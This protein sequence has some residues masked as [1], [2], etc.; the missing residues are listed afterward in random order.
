MEYTKETEIM[1][2]L[3][4]MEELLEEGKTS[5]ITS[6]VSI[7]RDE[8]FEYIKDIRMKLPTELQ[9]SVWIV[10]ERNKILAE[11]QGE[12][13]LIIQ[14][15]QETLQKM[16]EQHEIT[17]YAE[18]R[19]QMILENARKDS[20]EIRIGAIE[21]ANETVKGVEQQLKLTLESIHKEAQ[22]FENYI[23]NELRILYDHRQELKEMIHPQ[24]V[25]EERE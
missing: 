4:Q 15:A 11:A 19:A 16:I 23:T 22:N 14:E 18:D 6:K 10:E 8:F 7:D 3:D 2:L 13:K 20:R 24:P 12:A 5:F 17:K 21:Y 1:S 9:Q 25:M